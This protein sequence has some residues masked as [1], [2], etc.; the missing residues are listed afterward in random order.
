M[1][2]TFI[3]GSIGLGL[4]AGS[5]LNALSFRFHTGTSIMH[6]RSRCMRCGHTLSAL[7]LVPVLSYVLLGGRCRYCGVHISIQ[8]PLVEI[9]AGVLSLGVYLTNPSILMYAFW[10]FVW[11]LILFIVVYDIRHTVIP[12]S[13][14]L[15]LIGL[16]LLYIFANQSVP[17]EQLF[18]GPA[19]AA[20]L[21]FVSLISQGM[22]MGWGDGVFELSLGWLLGLTLGLSALMI[23]IWSGAL[24][25]VILI[26]V[27]RIVA[28][29]TPTA[30]SR[31]SKWGFTMRSELPFAPFLALGAA[32]C[33]FFHV[34]L[35]SHIAI[36]F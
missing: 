13:C 22:W 5:F 33:Y 1:S 19:L 11:M 10:F 36:F 16:S 23:A 2:L 8:Y 31:K 14:S 28:R 9:V 20:P 35:F 30:S 21:L 6:G 4:I 24:I 7:D 34:D 17:L 12:W 15:L 3:L 29:L 27:E 25:G 26:V 18:A 32:V